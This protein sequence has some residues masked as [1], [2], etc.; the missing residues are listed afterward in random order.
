MRIRSLLSVLMMAL[1]VVSFSNDAF[2]KKNKDGDE[3]A[4]D[5]PSF[6]IED[7]G[8]AKVDQFYDG[9][10]GMV[11]KLTQA[12]TEMDEA[13]AKL[14][15]ALGLAEGTPVADA[16]ADL[17]SKA[18]GKIELVLEGTKPTLKPAD[19]C[20][21]NVQNAIDATNAMADSLVNAAETLKSVAADVQPMIGQAGDMPA[22][23]NES[24]LGL[25][26]KGKALKTATANLSTTKK[27]AEEAN[28]LAGKANE[29]LELIKSTFGA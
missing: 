18:E 7:T 9:V 28:T 26:D 29:S 19:G 13:N 11:A 3:S 22:A 6:A 12:Q 17:Q 24:D 20:P 14:A 21:E 27:V 8:V 4:A 16:L 10:E 23:I 2:A 15:E 25:V 5:A 1:L